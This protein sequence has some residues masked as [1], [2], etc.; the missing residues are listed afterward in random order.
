MAM[1]TPADGNGYIGEC[2]SERPSHDALSN[3]AWLIAC[4]RPII[5]LEIQHCCFWNY[6][7]IF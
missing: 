3:Q 4:F 5:K 1:T 6:D 2:E 7:G